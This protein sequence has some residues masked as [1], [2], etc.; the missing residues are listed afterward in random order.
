MTELRP[1]LV[2]R[3]LRLRAR[4][5]RGR[6]GFGQRT[7]ARRGRP[8]WILQ[9]GANLLLRWAGERL[10]WPKVCVPGERAAEIVGFAWP[11]AEH[12][13]TYADVLHQADTIYHY[14]MVQASGGGVLNGIEPFEVVTRSFDGGASVRGLMPNTPGALDVQLLADNRPLLSWSYSAARQQ[15]APA[16]FRVYLTAGPTFDFANPDGSVDY[17]RGRTRYSWAGP[18]LSAG[19]VRYFTVRAESAAGVLSLIPRGGLCPAGSYDSV[20]LGRCPIVRV[21][22]GPPAPVED[23]WPEVS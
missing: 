13:Y 5:A 16:R 2:E 23:V 7:V 18:V 6:S 3:H 15:T 22:V 21:P 20:E 12:V 4:L 1:D 10:P 9:G 14:A 19:D 11:E 8:G 17:V